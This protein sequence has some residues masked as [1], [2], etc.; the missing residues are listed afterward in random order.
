MTAI[1]AYAKRGLAFV[2]G[3]SKRAGANFPV[4][5]VHRW[6]KDIVFA[7]AGNAL[8]LSNLIAQMMALRYQYGEHLDGFREAFAALRGHFHCQA[9]ASLKTSS[10]PHLVDTGG[11][12]LV[13]DGDSGQVYS[14]NFA[15]GSETP[16]GSSGVGGVVQGRAAAEQWSI[17]APALD[18]WAVNVI[19][20]CIGSSVDWPIDVL[21]ARP[22]DVVGALT[23]Q[24]RHKAGSAAPGDPAF[25]A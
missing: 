21:I 3:D 24:R 5:K 23:V 10:T 6:G 17:N 19:A 11:V 12:L 13:A 20:D 7:Q 9:I 22:D 2:A 16:L 18:V 14:F 8:F 4:T 1:V 25:G 15:D